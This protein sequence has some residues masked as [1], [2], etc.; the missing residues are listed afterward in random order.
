MLE[1]CAIRDQET[2]DMAVDTL[3]DRV[4]HMTIV[5]A[6]FFDA[7][8]RCHAWPEHPLGELLLGYSH[9]HAHASAAIGLLLMSR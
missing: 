4:V 6:S 2:V 8:C 7:V 5:L 9:T 1:R 3:M